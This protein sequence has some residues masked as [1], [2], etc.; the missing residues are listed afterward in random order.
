MEKLFKLHR[1]V[2]ARKKQIET[3]KNEIER[4]NQEISEAK[5]DMT[6]EDVLAN[7]EKNQFD[8]IQVN[9]EK[10][11]ILIQPANTD[12]AFLIWSTENPTGS[13]YSQISFNLKEGL[14]SKK[15]YV[16]CVC[17]G[18]LGEIINKSITMDTEEELKIKIK[19]G[20]I[21]KLQKICIKHKIR[22]IFARKVG[23]ICNGYKG[24]LLVKFIEAGNN[25]STISQYYNFDIA[26]S[27]LEFIN[28][29]ESYGMGFS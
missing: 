23:E 22:I 2:V 24:K 11:L 27:I 16:T 26:N 13:T 1:V 7:S 9:E 20:V 4:I 19:S 25:H 21:R 29:E 15:F 10:G 8:V 6:F 14:S 3:A 18:C 17:D 12:M 5:N 28:R